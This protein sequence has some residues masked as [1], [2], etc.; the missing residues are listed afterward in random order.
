MLTLLANHPLPLS[1]LALLALFCVGLYL[2]AILLPLG[3]LL[4]LFVFAFSFAV[5]KEKYQT[6]YQRG[7]ITQPELRSKTNQGLA[8]LAAALLLTIL[9]GMWV[10]GWVSGLAGNAVEARRS[11]WGSAT[12]SRGIPRVIFN[13]AQYNGSFCFT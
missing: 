7:E 6:Q 10:S 9:L 4:I 2:P 3:I 5:M 11:G 13:S 8:V 1:L 12:A